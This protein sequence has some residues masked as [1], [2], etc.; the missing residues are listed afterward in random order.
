MKTKRRRLIIAGILL[1]CAATLVLVWFCFK[2]RKWNEPAFENAEYEGVFCTMISDPAFSEEDFLTYRGLKIVKSSNLLKSFED[3]FSMTQTVFQYNPGVQNVYLE[4]DPMTLWEDVNR[5]TDK[6]AE[7]MEQYVLDTMRQQ[8]NTIFEIL[9]P[10]PKIT[11]FKNMDAAGWKEFE[12]IYTAFVSAFGSINNVLIYY[13]GAEQWLNS[14]QDNYVDTYKLNPQV[15]KK[16][17]LSAFC[18]RKYL[19]TA[20]EIEEKIRDIQIQEKEYQLRLEEYPN[21]SEWRFVFLGDSIFGIDMS[22]TSIPGVVGAMS[23]A[24]TYNCAKNGATAVYT[25]ED[26]RTFLGVTEALI[27]G[28]YGNI[29]DIDLLE[30]MDLFLQDYQTSDKVC[31]FLNFGLNDYFQGCPLENQEN[32]YDETT[33]K[34]AL[35]VGVKQ[36]REHYPQA[37]IVLLIPTYIYTSDEGNIQYGK[38]EE[39]LSDY[40]EAAKSVAEEMG[41]YC[42]DNYLDLPVN[43]SNHQVY[44]SDE[45]HLNEKGRFIFGEQ[46]VFFLKAYIDWEE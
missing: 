10:S 19:I 9:L 31:F 35:R 45:C 37:E 44:L 2:N 22:T 34:G 15:E 20:D 18:D 27:T 42:K 39:V 17:F 21:F 11:Y 16:I 29:S 3:I 12:T 32:V 14:N 25:D 13:V 38:S 1:F 6:W 5:R 33:Y 7:R 40:R 23:G 46:L 43:A 41:I 8:S 26:E 30:N 28:N 24:A 4:I 36:L